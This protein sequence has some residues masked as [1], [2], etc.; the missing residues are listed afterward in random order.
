VIRI[1][2][3][4]RRRAPARLLL[5]LAVLVIA[6]A[7]PPPP[8][9]PVSSD[10]APVESFRVLDAG[11]YNDRIDEALAAGEP[12]PRSALETA[13]AFFGGPEEANR[14]VFRKE[15]AP[16]ER[17]REA[18]IVVVQEGLLDDSVLGSRFEFDLFREDDGSWRVREVRGSWRCRRGDYQ[19]D[20]YGE[21]YCP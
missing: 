1:A 15:S 4:A 6:C 5:S 10:E 20:G 7:G 14:I 12:W 2:T 9:V 8:A 11:P 16:G 21:R 17:P 18:V 3:F 19:I 13:A